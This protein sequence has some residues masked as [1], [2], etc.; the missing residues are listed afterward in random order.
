MEQPAESTNWEGYRALPEDQRWELIDGQLYQMSSSPRFIHQ[1][2]VGSFHLEMALALKG[3]RCQV[4]LSPLDVKLSE[5]NAVQ[6]DLLVLCDRSMIKDTHIEGP[7]SLVVEILSPSSYRHDRVRK[8]GLYAR[9][10]IQEYWIVTPEP[11]T[12]EV[13]VWDAGSYRVSGSYRPPGLFRS[14]TIPELELDLTALFEPSGPDPDDEV[15]EAA[16]EYVAE[17]LRAGG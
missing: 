10:A 13:L 7:P 9:F 1:A 16:P 12:L 6:P 2:L 8:L 5:I 17:L 15:R 11:A 14:P 4:Y 3:K